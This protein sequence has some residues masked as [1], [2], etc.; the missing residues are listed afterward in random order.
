M[1][2]I[3][4]RVEGERMAGAWL[5]S[6][7]LVTEVPC[8]RVMVNPDLIRLNA[9]S[10]LLAILAIHL[11]SSESEPRT[12]HSL[13]DILQ[14]SDEYAHQICMPKPA[15]H[16]QDQYHSLNLKSREHHL[17]TLHSSQQLRPSQVTGTTLHHHH[18]TSWISNT[19]PT[20][21]V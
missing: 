11:A 9:E 15:E 20:Q 5:G 10:L 16:R 6:T 14:V 8:G 1:S 12:S 19:T 17:I 2:I 7:V 4:E 21:A 18:Q 3:L 13:Q